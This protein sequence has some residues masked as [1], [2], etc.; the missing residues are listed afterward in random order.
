M[1]G[2]WY[3]VCHVRVALGTHFS[4]FAPHSCPS[5]AAREHT[6]CMGGCCALSDATRAY[7]AQSL[8]FSTPAVAIRRRPFTNAI[9]FSVVCSGGKCG[10]GK[11]PPELNVN[12]GSF[13]TKYSMETNFILP[14]VRGCT[15]NADISFH[16]A[17]LRHIARRQPRCTPSMADMPRYLFP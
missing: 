17:E 16:S 12:A 15:Q 6:R 1:P 5:P 11:L 13:E 3:V 9:V 2:A 7:A 4:C 14:K 8:Q 10:R